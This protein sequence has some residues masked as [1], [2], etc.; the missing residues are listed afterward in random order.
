[1]T[2]GEMAQAV[3]WA[4]LGVRRRADHGQAARAPLAVVAGALA[5]AFAFVATLALVVW[6]VTS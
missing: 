3:L 2:V 5:C 6:M 1:M 4:A